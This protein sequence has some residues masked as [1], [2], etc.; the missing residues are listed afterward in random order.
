MINRARHSRLRNQK[1]ADDELVRMQ[2]HETVFMESPPA[3]VL[4]EQPGGTKDLGFIADRVRKL[5][6]DGHSSHRRLV[7]SELQIVACHWI[8]NYVLLGSRSKPCTDCIRYCTIDRPWWPD[9]LHHDIASPIFR[10]PAEA[11]P[12]WVSHFQRLV[13]KA[14]AMSCKLAEIDYDAL[15]G[16]RLC[17]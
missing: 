1:H 3:T 7:S 12:F 13:Q 6:T 10:S 9:L 17:L 14:K 5:N 8:P 16:L 2:P 15:F 11:A 4:V